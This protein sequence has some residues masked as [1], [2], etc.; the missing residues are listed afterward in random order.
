MLQRRTRMSKGRLRKCMILDLERE[1]EN[2]ALGGMRD[3]VWR[4]HQARRAAD[5]NV[6]LFRRGE[7]REGNGEESREEHDVGRRGGGTAIG[8]IS[9]EVR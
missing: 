8:L 3:V 9:V 6:P 4:I 7:S 2:V 5:S 1:P